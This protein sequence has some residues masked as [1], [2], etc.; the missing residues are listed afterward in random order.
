[1]K[2]SVLMSIYHKEN[3]EYFDRTMQSI[4][5]EQSVKPDEIVLVQ[6]GKLTDDLYIIIEKWKI[7]LGDILKIIPL[8]QNVGL[9]NALNIGLKECSYDLVARMDT[10]DICMPNRFEKQ[11]NFFENNDVD[12]IGSYCIEIDEDENRENLRKMPLNHQDIYDNL[13]TNPFIHPSMMFKKSIIEKVSGYDKILTRRQDYDL[14]FK[15]AKAGAKFANIDEPLLLYRFTNDTHKKQNLNL[16]LSQAKIGYKGVKLLNQQ[17]WKAIACYVPVV[18]S[19]L[20]NK[21]QHIIY[22]VLKKFDPRQK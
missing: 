21:I 3:S 17:Y 15:C 13:F 6:D 18:R 1:M 4:W 2:F 5:N 20:P 19:L 22:K 14:W 9:G 16:M 11:I 8:K 10:D 7:I 12:I